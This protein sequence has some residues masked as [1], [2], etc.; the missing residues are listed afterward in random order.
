PASRD[1]GAAVRLSNSSPRL[2]VPSR[3]ATMTSGFSA[4]PRKEGSWTK[5]VIF[6][7][8]YA[9]LLESIVEWVLVLYLYGKGLVDSKMTVSVVLAL[10]ASFLSI[11]VAGLQSLV[12]WQYNKIGGFG[13]QKTVL[14]NLCTYVYRLDLMAWLAT[15]VSGLV[16]VAQ[17]ADCLRDGT[18]AGLWRVGLGCS[19]H[20]ASVVV[21]VVSLVTVCTIYCARE[22]CERPYDIS[23][24]GIYTRQ[25]TLRDDSV[26]SG[27][28]WD[29]D[30][31][32][33][34]EIL[35][36]CR[37]HDGTIKGEW[38]SPDPLAAKV[39]C[40]PS[41]RQPAPVRLRPQLHL[42]TD[43][44]SECGEI[45]PSGTTVS[46]DENFS[47]ISLGGQSAVSEMY[48]ISR[49]STIMISPTA[50]ESRGLISGLTSV[51]KVPAIP[52]QYT[53][54]HKR[55]KSSVS[56][57]RRFLPKAFPLFLPLSLDPQIRALADPNAASDVEKQVATPSIAP[58]SRSSSTVHQAIQTSS[59]TPATPA[60][61]DADSKAQLLTAL[62]DSNERTMTMNSADAPEVV[63][64]ETKPTVKR[65]QTACLAA[66]SIHHPHHPNY[67]PG[68][69]ANP[70]TQTQPTFSAR[71]YSLAWR[72]QNGTVQMDPAMTRSSTRATTAF[73]CCPSP[74]IHPRLPDA[75]R[76]SCPRRNDVEVI[77]PSTRRPRSTTYGATGGVGPLSCIMES[78]STPRASADESQLSASADAMRTYRGANRTSLG[79][80]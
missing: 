29:S 16:I 4:T 55:G 20:R 40:H 3:S 41:I 67:I 8:L 1:S 24:I 35:N 42:N 19:L 12:A 72:H 32:L 26:F 39:N 31:T 37:Q 71:T 43:P 15:S 21:S 25:P 73:S 56:S 60:R 62:P 59:D 78:T 46:P 51:P 66:R 61:N 63:P 33:K 69:P 23:L 64:S 6:V 5:L 13:T 74:R 36:L 50:S 9:L 44:G 11:P 58:H 76:C 77:Y 27:H 10:V 52:E 57:F 30:E 68:H 53:T 17:Q 75:S 48:P 7:A 65:S 70:Q 80:Y 2:C 34:N 14:H 38:W 22:L 47:H 18:D 28:S 49:T 79:F 45:V 54:K